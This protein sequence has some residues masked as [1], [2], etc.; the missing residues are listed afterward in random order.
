MDPRQGHL[1]A[2]VLL[3]NQ[4]DYEHNRRRGVNG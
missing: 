3:I 1:D 2:V 4:K